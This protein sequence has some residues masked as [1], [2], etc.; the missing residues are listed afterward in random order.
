MST[1]EK[2]RGQLCKNMVSMPLTNRE[3]QILQL[4]IAELTTEEIAKHLSIS[5]ATVE[6]HRRHLLRKMG[7]K[8]VVG[9]VK[10]AI[11]QNLVS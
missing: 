3:I 9:L 8:S 2:I 10:E 7:V 1:Y 5:I 6:T 11:R 4:I